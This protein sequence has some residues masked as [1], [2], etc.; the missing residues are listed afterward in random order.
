MDARDYRF[1]TICI[2]RKVC[3]EEKSV[4]LELR[5]LWKLDL[6]QLKFACAFVQWGQPFRLSQVA[7]GK[8]L[9]IRND[10]IVLVDGTEANRET[11]GFCFVR[12]SVC[13]SE[14]VWKS[15]MFIY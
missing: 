7:S 2:S 3:F 10:R 9:G 6:F 8:F 12:K 15:M 13:Q 1:C 4:A 14:L 5:S 11:C